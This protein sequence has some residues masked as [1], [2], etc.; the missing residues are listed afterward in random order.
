MF[1]LFF[2]PLLFFF[3]TPNMIRFYSYTAFKNFSWKSSGDHICCQE[4]S[5]AQPCSWQTHYLMYSLPKSPPSTI[6]YFILLG[7]RNLQKTVILAW[8]FQSMNYMQMDLFSCQNKQIC[9]IFP[10]FKFTRFYTCVPWA[11]MVLNSL[12]DMKESMCQISLC[13]HKALRECLFPCNLTLSFS[14]F[15]SLFWL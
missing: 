14:H 10:K 7:E 8:H 4:L 11:K 6:Q 3:A 1:F 15:C 9:L 2:F 12:W 13:F 5:L